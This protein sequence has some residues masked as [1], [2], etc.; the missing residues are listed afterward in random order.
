MEN[1][2]NEVKEKIQNSKTEEELTNLW[3]EYLGKKG[4]VRDLMDKIKEISNEEKKNYGQSV[5]K[6]RTELDDLINSAKNALQ[7]GAN[8][9]YLNKS[10]V[11]LSSK[12]QKVGHLHPLTET[13][14]EI[15]NI[16]KRMGYSVYDGPELET[17][18]YLFQRCNLPLHH[19]ARDLQDS[20][21]VDE[22]NILLRTQTSSVEA[23][24]L[25]DLEPPFKIVVPGRV[26][27]NEKVNKSN[28]FLFHQ[29]QLTCVQ[30]KVSLSELFATVTHMFKEFYGDDVKIRF[31]TKYY[32]E[33]EPGAGV[34]MQCPF[35]KGEGCVVCKKR[36]WLEMAGSGI[37]HPNMMRMAGIDTNKW[38]GFAFGFGLDRLAMTKHDIRDIRTLL[39][40]D[41]AYKT[42]VR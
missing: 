4:K 34:D 27:R 6:L 33:V 22:P 39:G 40:G 19:P 15:N 41:L 17:D 1:I 2:I 7:S 37:I 28:H 12:K 9:E 16:F 26:Y 25:Q 42:Y 24:A 29:Y 20:I 10:L 31:R 36:G 38:Q 23:H 13:I 21:F 14:N 8:S 32:P 11:K 5:N 18:E 3:R 35:C 30:E